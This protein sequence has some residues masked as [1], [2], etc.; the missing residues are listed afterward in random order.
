MIIENSELLS[1]SILAVLEGD[2]TFRNTT[3]SKTYI[4]PHGSKYYVSHEGTIISNP[5]E[6]SRYFNPNEGSKHFNQNEGSRAVNKTSWSGILKKEK[7][8]EIRSFLKGAFTEDLPLLGGDEF[9]E[10]SGEELLGFTKAVSN[11]DIG[12]LPYILE[13]DLIQSESDIYEHK[14]FLRGLLSVHGQFLGESQFDSMSNEELLGFFKKLWKGIKKGVSKVGKFIGKVGKGVGKFVG[15]VGKG[16]GKVIGNVAKG[17]WKGAGAVAKFVSKNAGTLLKA[18]LSFLP[19][20]SIIASGIEGIEQMMS[21]NNEGNQQS[22]SLRNENY[23]DNS[24]EYYTPEVSEV[25]PQYEETAYEEEQPMYY[26]DGSPIYD[27]Y[28]NIIQY[29]EGVSGLGEG[30]FQKLGKITKFVADPTNQRKVAGYL[31]NQANVETLR[32]QGNKQVNFFA[33]QGQREAVVKYSAGTGIQNFMSTYGIYVVVGLAALFLI[34]SL[35]TK[36]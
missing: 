33:D 36:K 13:G 25:M 30:F 14:D 31:T 4:N 10:M 24:N 17:V 6:G 20:G 18:G 16:V 15:K 22:E 2:S 29:E 23:P 27:D 35:N 8:K 3:G 21:K 7:D 1:G 26:E 11:E 9:D 19:G 5:N 12:I 32:T 34:Y 28:G